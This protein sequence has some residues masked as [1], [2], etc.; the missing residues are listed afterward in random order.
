MPTRNLY[1]AIVDLAMIMKDTG[2][3]RMSWVTVLCF[4]SAVCLAQQAL[5]LDS[6]S[7]TIDASEIQVLDVTDRQMEW[8]EIAKR[9]V[10]SEFIPAEEVS[11]PASGSNTYWIKFT[12]E[13][14]LNDVDEWLLDFDKW[15]YVN[16][17]AGIEGQDFAES[18]AGHLIPFKERDY[19]KANKNL[20]RSQIEPGERMQYFVRLETG[21]NYYA[22]PVNMGFKVTTVQNRMATDQ[23]IRALIFLFLGIYLV[24]FFYNLF[25]YISTRERAY[26][27]YLMILAVMSLVVLH[28]FGYFVELFGGFRQYVFWHGPVEMILSSLIG[29]T[30]FLFAK[31]FLN[32]KQNLPFWNKV[33]NVLMVVVILM[34]I[35][36]FFGATLLNYNLSSLFGIISLGVVFTIGIRSYRKNVPSAGYFAL[37]YGVFIVSVIIFLIGELGGLWTGEYTPFIV[38]AGSTGEVILFSLA[39]GNRINL[40]RK[41]NEQKQK[42]L[43]EQLQ[44]NQ[45]LQTKV[46]RELEQKVKER[47]VEIEKQREQIAEEKE[48]S[49]NLLLN[50]LPKATAEELKEKG[51]ASAKYYDQVT[52]VFTDFV[53]FTK[54]SEIIPPQELVEDLDY[55]FK[56]FDEIAI[57]HNLEKIKTIGD[58]YMCAG[59]IPI[60]NDHHAVDAV[61]ASLEMKQFIENWKVQ[62]EQL[63]K[64]AWEIRVGLHSG[65]VIA[66]VVGKSKLAYDIWGDTVNTASRMES[67]GESSKINISGVTYE[68]VKEFFDCEYRGKIKVKN[69]DE[70]DMYFVIGEKEDTANELHT[71]PV[72]SDEPF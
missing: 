71:Q 47:T 56:A 6:E 60:S 48:R 72:T 46:N 35:P 24:M 68:A 36:S 52:V 57:K 32:L 65:E 53:G 45:A 14:R 33:L 58:A 5:I 67:A 34:P 31:S 43:I 38:Q 63:D 40:L 2:I 61:R 29:I 28:N 12:L 49:E 27:Y 18:V 39:L 30:V 44:E 1:F 55:C 16:V 59:G 54:L 4:L 62:R 22:R 13:N 9:D 64:H 15:I 7:I 51:Y 11:I 19:P 10:Q 42:Q 66:G 70:I 8:P 20:I 25:L 26:L 69:K 17:F 41:D 50:I 37:A 23:R 3:T 21:D